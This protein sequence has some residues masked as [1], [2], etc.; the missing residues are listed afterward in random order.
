M[1]G[2]VSLALACGGTTAA[3]QPCNVEY[4]CPSGQTCWTTDGKTFSCMPSGTI[5][6]GATC[7][8]TPGS[9]LCADRLACVA[10]GV[11]T[12][13]QCDY[14]CD[15]SNPCPLGGCVTITDGMSV[16]VS[17]CETGSLGTAS[18]CNV[19]YDCPKGQ[20]CW[21]T[22]GFAFEC[23]ASGA[24]KAGTACAVIFGSA[25]CG[26]ELACVS[27]TDADQGECDYW[28]DASHPCAS[29]TCM[30]IADSNGVEIRLCQ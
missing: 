8:S 3:S 27:T 14:W 18:S 28:C 20:T 1:G 11:P 19:N 17:F 6:P 2:T 12:D 26:D 16:T 15:P 7:D 22:D 24:A 9:A 25:T 23:M 21:T 5:P 30:T 4:N 29:G 13:G 10:E